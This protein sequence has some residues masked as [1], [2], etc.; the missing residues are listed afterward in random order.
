MKFKLFY[1]RGSSFDNEILRSIL[2]CGQVQD[3]VTGKD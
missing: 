2:Q 3:N 1:E